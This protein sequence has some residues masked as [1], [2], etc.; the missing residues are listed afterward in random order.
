MVII[1]LIIIIIMVIIIIII[2]TTTT[3]III[4]TII[5]IIIIII[6]V[7]VVVYTAKYEVQIDPFNGF[8]IAKRIIGL[9]GTNMKKICIDTDCKLRLRGRG[10]GY[11]EGEEKKEANES[12]H[13]CVSC[14]KY[15]HY[16]LAKKLI[17]QLL[18][19]IYMDYD[20]WLF[21][22]GKP[23]ANLKPKTYEKF[24]PFFKFHQN[25]NQKQNVNQN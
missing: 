15:D 4:T 8:D 5:I 3:T 9:K 11:L 25:S 2:I 16:I 14:Q 17:E 22:H 6:V 10:S 24:I 7:V 21:N 23:Y 19:K 13:L 12:L 20:T 1:L 18:V